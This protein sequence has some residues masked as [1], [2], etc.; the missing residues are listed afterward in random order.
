MRNSVQPLIISELVWKPKS[1]LKPNEMSNINPNRSIKEKFKEQANNSW[2]RE[3]N[4]K[5][6]AIE[7]YKE[8]GIRNDS[9]R[10]NCNDQEIVN[11]SEN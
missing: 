10:A 11:D 2:R 9:G 4:K 3:E 5:Y 6:E 7:K 8:E 1:M